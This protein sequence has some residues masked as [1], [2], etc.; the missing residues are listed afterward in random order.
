MYYKK[1]SPCCVCTRPFPENLMMEIM[2]KELICPQCGQAIKD[3]YLSNQVL[4][5]KG[6]L[7]DVPVMGNKI[8]GKN[9]V[10]AWIRAAVEAYEK[11]C[12][13]DPNR[14]ARHDE[15]ISLAAGMSVRLEQGDFDGDPKQCFEALWA[16]HAENK[17]KRYIDMIGDCGEDLSHEELC[18]LLVLPRPELDQMM[19][20]VN[21]IIEHNSDA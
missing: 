16:F 3:R 19:E 12:K 15:Y 7:D 21:F 20:L 10:G 13:A 14:A 17:F 6:K 2:D 8:N 9:F 18:E 11:S 1:N 4:F 5:D